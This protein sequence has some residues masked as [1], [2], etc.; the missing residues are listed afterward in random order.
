MGFYHQRFVTTVMLE[1]A[2]FSS[3]CSVLLLSQIFLSLH[4]VY[5]NYMD[6]LLTVDTQSFYLPESCLTT[7]FAIQ[8]INS[9]LGTVIY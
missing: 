1:K 6:K 3:I 7:Y 2:G 9:V 4:D 5:S 8:I